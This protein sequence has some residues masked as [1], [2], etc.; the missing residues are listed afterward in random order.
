[1]GESASHDF[2]S[3]LDFAGELMD[4]DDGQ[5]DAVFAQVPTVFHH[6]VLDHVGAGAGIDTD[7]PDIDPAGLACS[8]FVE[9]ENVAALDQNRFANRAVHGAGHFRVQLQLAILAVDGNEVFR[10]HQVDDQLQFVLAGVTADVHRR[11]GAVVINHL[12]LR[13]E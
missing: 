2:R 3:G 11:V 8:Q 1:G 4:S 9:L 10:L 13:A 5:H 7:P 12:S 6:Q